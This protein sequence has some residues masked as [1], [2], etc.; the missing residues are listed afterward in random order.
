MNTEELIKKYGIDLESLKIEQI[1]LARE[2]EIKDNIDFSLIDKFGA[3][4]NIFV[5]SKLLSCI[6]VCNKDFEVIDRS[7]VFEKT[8]FPYIA[9]FRNYRELEPMIMAFEKLNERPD[10]ILIPAH[11]LTHPR[12]GLA[13][14]F[15]LATGVP[16]IGVSNVIVD[17]EIKDDNIFK[18]EKQVGKILKSKEKANPLFIS[19]GNNLTID[20]AYKIAESLIKPPHKKPE[21]MHLARKYAK[22]VKKELV[23]E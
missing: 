7:Y 2:L 9:E 1:K 19:P 5:G 10:V 6:I 17:C 22:E 13:S 20:T 18:D 14:H 21:P 3:I 16:T 11:G 8:K 12:L 4:E 15:G 23:R